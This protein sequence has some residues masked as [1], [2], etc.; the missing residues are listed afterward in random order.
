MA[1]Y[2]KTVILIEELSEMLEIDFY[3]NKEKK[4]IKKQIQALRKYLATKN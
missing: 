1:D 3:S 4:E 2:M